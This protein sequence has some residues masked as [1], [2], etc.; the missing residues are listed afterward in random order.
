MG[1]FE[2]QVAIV[3]GGGSGI[4]AAIAARFAEEGARIV[5]AGRTESKLA[6]Q[7]EA[8]GGGKSIRW[9]VADVGVQA[10]VEALIAFAVAEFGQLDVL[11]NNAGFGGFGRVTQIDPAS[12]HAQFAT[13]VDSVFYACRAAIPHL[14]KTKG[15]I[16]NISST[17]GT[18][19]DYGQN[20]YNA[21][22]A[23]VINL[24]RAIAIDHAGQGIRV[25]CVSPGLI[26][27]PMLDE[28]PPEAL[29]AWDSVVP[30]GRPGMPEEIAA[31][32]AFL[33]SRDAS[34]VTGQNF[35]VDGGMTAHTGSPN[36]LRIFGM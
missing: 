6:A 14:V 4:G 35:V 29:K 26:I 10:D 21:G 23:A 28:M 1:R 34:Y 19:G 24:T 32:V 9:R 33:A 13:N 3:T 16:I 18:A 22:K 27:T 12:W 2:N 31:V 5:L 15:S 30:M 25:N 11:I 36:L 20:A 7:A 17:S 8:L